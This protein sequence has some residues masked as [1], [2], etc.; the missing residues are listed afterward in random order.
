MNGW[1]VEHM[2]KQLRIISWCREGHDQ[3]IHISRPYNHD[4][5]TVR[6]SIECIICDELAV[7]EVQG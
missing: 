3:R 5:D 2:L 6:V 1:E 7:L 4:P